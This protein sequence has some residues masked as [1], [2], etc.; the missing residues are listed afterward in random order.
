MLFIFV[1]MCSLHG[2]AQINIGYNVKIQDTIEVDK[3]QFKTIGYSSY[4]LATEP[5]DYRI[6]NPA[7]ARILN[8]ETIIKVELVYTDFPKGDNFSDLNK[9]RIIEL[10]MHLP[11]AFNRQVVQWVAVKQTGPKKASDLSKYFHGFVIH[12]RPIPPYQEESNIIDNVI[13]GIVAP[14]DST[15]LKVFKRNAQWKD[16]LIVCDVT[17]SMAPYSAQLALWL[18]LNSTLKTAKQFVFFN[19]DEEN[20]NTQEKELDKTGM[21]DVESYKFDKVVKVIK[22][23]MQKG[24]HVENNLEAVFYALKKYPGSKKNVL[25]IADN[26]EDPCDMKLL[27]KLKEMKVPLRII[28]C[29]V[30]AS[31]NTKYLEMAYA[32]GGSVHTMEQDLTDLAKLANGKTIKIGTMEFKLAGGKF[33]QMN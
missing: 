21:W 30:N 5:G 19:D 22:E 27:A 26:W 33:Y 16:M 23:A 28:V 29:G 25:M 1:G 8:N 13:N 18:K 14:S 3:Y 11:S 20:S 2:V 24:N 31:F 32:T 6:L 15:L 4:Y 7:A 12:Y 10:F 17:G 9:K